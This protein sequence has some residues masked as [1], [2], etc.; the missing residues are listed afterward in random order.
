MRPGRRRCVGRSRDAAGGILLV[1]LGHVDLRVR[2]LDDAEA[3][4]EALLPPLGFT[5]RYHAGGWKVWAAGRS[6]VALTE[7][8]EHAANEN[9]VAF[10]VDSREQVEA[11][12]EI[13]RGAGALELSGPKEMPYGPGYYAV[14]FADPSGNRLEVYHRPS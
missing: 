14:F 11:A 9:R 5:D 7:S 6:Y 3:F 13:A 2:D 1:V 4:Y 8:A 10:A 12:A